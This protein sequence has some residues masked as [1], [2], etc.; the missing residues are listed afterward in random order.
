MHKRA[1]LGTECSWV[2]AGRHPA[3]FVLTCVPCK[4]KH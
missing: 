4:L 2:C 1:Y 3:G